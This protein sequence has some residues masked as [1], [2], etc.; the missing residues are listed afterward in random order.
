MQPLIEHFVFLSGLRD[1]TALNRGLMQALTD[2]LQPESA[3]LFRILQGGQR[4]LI[5]PTCHYAYGLLEVHDAYLPN[6]GLCRPVEVDD[7]IQ[8]CANSGQGQQVELEKKI[9]RYVCPIV[10]DKTVLFL[11][12]IRRSKIPSP[13]YTLLGHLLAFFTHHLSLIEYSE[14][15]SLTRLLNRKTFDEHMFHIL[16][17]AKADA[18]ENTDLPR[19]RMGSEGDTRHYLAVADIDHFKRVNDTYGH[20][21]GD[22]VLILVA[23]L[24]RESLRL[25]DQLFRFGGEEFVAILQPATM[26]AAEEVLQRVR[27]TIEAYAF[28][29]AGHITLSIGFTAIN[30][31][32]TPTRLLDRADEALYFAKDNGRNQIHAYENLV[33]AG[34]LLGT[35]VNTASNLELF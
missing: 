27:R 34:L 16:G 4:Y 10:V 25:D 11:L 18:T 6:H 33:A 8:Q 1:R 14:T 9:H 5:Q 32:D 26:K 17:Q 7:L 15:D 21:I 29:Q 22:E 35:D 30:S 23:R 28:P 3:T 24:M 31:Q 2:L 12:D 13:Q 20:L 19:R